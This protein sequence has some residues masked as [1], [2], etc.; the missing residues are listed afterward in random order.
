MSTELTGVLHS[1]HAC[2]P[3]GEIPSVAASPGFAVDDTLGALLLIP[4]CVHGAAPVHLVGCPQ[5][6]DADRKGVIL[7]RDFVGQLAPL[8]STSISSVQELAEAAEL[9]RMRSY[10]A[11]PIQN[12]K[13]TMSMLTVGQRPSTGER[14]SVFAGGA[15]GMSPIR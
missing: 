10:V 5:D 7:L 4:Y 9:E 2:N 14:G 12:L 8:C 6:L 1:P 15:M 11:E 3:A 13:E